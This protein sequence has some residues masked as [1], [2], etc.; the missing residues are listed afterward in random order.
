MI[1]LR[2][3]GRIVSDHFLNSSAKGL[4]A[5]PSAQALSGD[6]RRSTGVLRNTCPAWAFSPIPDGQVSGRRKCR[7]GRRREQVSHQELN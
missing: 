2:G 1:H 4:P 6:R 5:P 7:G 3:F